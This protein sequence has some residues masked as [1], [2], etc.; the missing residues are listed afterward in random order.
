M[1]AKNAAKTPRKG[2]DTARTP[3]NGLQGLAAR[4]QGGPKADAALKNRTAAKSL[5][6]RAPSGAAT[7]AARVRSMN[8]WR[9]SY[10]P[11]RGLTMARAVSLIE[12][13]PRGEFADLMWTFG[14]PFVGIEC[15]DPDLLALIECR[16]S[17]LEEMDWNAKIVDRDGIDQKLAEEQQAAVRELFDGIQNLYEAIAHL[18][19]AAF[20]GFAHCEKIHSSDGDL[21]ELRCIDQWNIVRDGT[22]GAWKYNPEARPVGFAGLGDDLLIEPEHFVI[23]ECPRPIHRVALPKWIRQGLGDKDWDAFLEIY[24]VPGGIV[25]GPPNVPEGKEAEYEAAAREAAQGGSGY[26]PNGSAYEANDAPRGV[27]PFRDRLDYLSERL[28]LAGT[29]GKLT[30]LTEAGSGTLAG[31]AHQETFERIGRA[32]ARRIGEILHKALVVPMLQEHFPGKDELA[33]FELAFREEV[34]A[35]QVVEDAAK[36]SAAG[37]QIDPDE[38]SEKAGYKLTL[39][40]NENPD[41]PGDGA[42]GKRGAKPGGPADPQEDPQA[43][44]AAKAKASLKNSTA[45]RRAVL[46]AL[47]PM[48]DEIAEALAGGDAGLRAL[49]ARLP[50]IL[51]EL[52]ATPAA[53]AV[54]EEEFARQYVRGARLANA[55]HSKRWPAGRPEGGQFAPE[56]GGGFSSSPG[57]KTDKNGGSNGTSK[58]TPAGERNLE[59]G[60]GGTAGGDRPAEAGDSGRGAGDGAARSTGA[61]DSV[62]LSLEA[63]ERSAGENREQQLAADR[64][65]LARMRKSGE[66]ATVTPNPANNLAQGSE[67]RIELSED[68][69]RVLKHTTDGYFGFQP[70]VSRSGKVTLKASSASEYLQRMEMQNE[71]FGSDLR[72]E[73]SHD[74]G[75][76]GITFSQR[77]ISGTTPSDAEIES[78]MTSRGF[79][80][81]DDSRVIDR[82]LRGTTYHHA[83]TG[84]IAADVRG[85]N[86]KKGDD[87]TLYPLDLMMNHAPAGSALDRA[88]RE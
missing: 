27:N 15:A 39:K 58:S 29:G 17:V 51:G 16:T 69:T 65:A 87:G 20:R 75:L 26:L 37:Y 43:A 22:R 52:N 24:G 64:Q 7:V 53:A 11:M 50:E 19:L 10:N 60:G 28:V 62:S 68:G 82:S 4:L 34:D 78:F 2:R 36:L 38:L 77:Y 47:A 86:F 32:E 57:T 85:P 40:S 63:A 83:E 55:R 33:Y 46:A 88:I 41:H 1:S 6:G 54:I 13:Y 9:D 8:R 12:A 73:G 61:P 81:V 59:K 30:M 44:A 70:D 76:G 79:T 45:T 49:R 14:A 72:F 80:K 5:T 71:V 66:V 25:I 74:E 67:H 48:Q 42:P 3:K 21:V 84:Y 18:E 31:G 23:R 35:G 56:N